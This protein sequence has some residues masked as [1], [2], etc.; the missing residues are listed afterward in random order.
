M[1]RKSNT[2]PFEWLQSPIIYQQNAPIA[3]QLWQLCADFFN[4]RGNIHHYLGIAKSALQNSEGQQIG[5]KKLFYVLRPLLSAKWCLEKQQIAPMA[6]TPLL[7]LLPDDL[8]QQINDI[9][10]LKATMTESTP[11]TIDPKILLFI[12][13]SMIEIK[14]SLQAIDEQ[15]FKADKLDYFFIQTLMSLK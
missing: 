12:E 8:S 4:A 3:N 14:E 7:T 13:Q 5:I 10:A 9:I 6:I 1:I 11:I 15:H 2:T